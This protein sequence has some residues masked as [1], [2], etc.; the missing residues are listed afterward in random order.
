MERQTSQMHDLLEQS[1]PQSDVDETSEGK[2][3][4][5]RSFFNFPFSS[6]EVYQQ[7]LADLLAR[8]VLNER[9]EIEKAEIILQMQLFYF[10]RVTGQNLTAKDIRSHQDAAD[11]SNFTETMNVPPSSSNYQDR[12]TR[13]LTF[14]ELKALIEQGKT[15]S[16]PN[17]KVIPDTL[18]DAPPSTSIAPV[19]KKPWELNN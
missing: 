2:E 14:A 4:G 15:D 16:I 7:G 11:P 17:N 12:E 13:P 9:S 8:D 6:D 3:S 19:R 1:P 18:N 10:N 5:L